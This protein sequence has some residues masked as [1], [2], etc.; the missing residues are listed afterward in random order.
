MA[1]AARND[2]SGASAMKSTL[3]PKALWARLQRLHG[4]VDKVYTQTFGSFDLLL[5]GGDQ[6][7]SDAMWAVLPELQA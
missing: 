5:L 4:L 3:V 7:Y 1:Y 2:F 6:V